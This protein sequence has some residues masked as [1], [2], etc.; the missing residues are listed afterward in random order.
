M[1]PL[2]LPV[3]EATG[4]NPSL[5]FTD[6][7]RQRTSPVESLYNIPQLRLIQG[8]KISALYSFRAQSVPEP[9]INRLSLP[10]GLRRLYAARPSHL[11]LVEEP[12]CF[13]MTQTLIL[14]P[15]QLFDFFT[16]PPWMIH[17]FP[18]ES[19]S[20][21]DKSSTSPITF[22]SIYHHHIS[23]PLSYQFFTDGSKSDGH[24]GCGVVFHLIH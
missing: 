13:C 16:F 6:L 22:H 21:F 4:Y 9:P 20:G 19:F 1:A 5:C 17:N 11:P 7:H 14:F 24:V 10:A 12:K 23:I 18:F 15:F 3:F 2:V 8:D